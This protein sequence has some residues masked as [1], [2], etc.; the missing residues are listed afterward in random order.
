[1]VLWRFGDV[2]K[3]NKIEKDRRNHFR[4]NVFIKLLGSFILV[5]FI[6][7]II[8]IFLYNNVESSLIENANQSNQALLEQAQIV[9][10]SKIK[11][12]D[13]LTLQIAL[14]PNLQLLLFSGES[15][16]P[17]DNYKYIEFIKQLSRYRTVSNFIEEFYVYFADTDVILTTAIKTNSFMFYNFIQDYK[18][19]EI[20]EVMDILQSYQLKTYLPSQQMRTITDGNKITFVQSLPLGEKSDIKGSFVILIDENKIKELLLNQEGMQGSYYILNRN[21]EMIFSTDMNEENYA[22]IQKGLGV[23]SNRFYTLDDHE[24][25]I[26]YRLSALNDWT[27]VSIV[28]KDIVLSRVNEVK[29]LALVLVLLCLLAG[30]IVS[31]YLTYKNHSPIRDVIHAILTGKQESNHETTIKNEFDFIKNAV[32][33][34]L[35]EENKLR[36]V[37]NQ[38]APVIKADFISRLIKGNVDASSITKKD[39]DFMGVHFPTIYFRVVIIHI[40]DCNRFIQEDTERERALIRFIILNLSHELLK[41]T[42]YV[43]EIE[44]D[45]IA[46]LLNQTE[47]ASKNVLQLKEFIE[48]LREI[49]ENR[50]KTL[51]TVAV[52]KTVDGMKHIPKAYLGALMALDHKMIQGQHS[53]IFYDDIQII[54]NDYFFYSMEAE[55]QIMNYAKSGDYHNIEKMLNHIFE[56]NFHKSGISPE[57]GKCLFFEIFSTILKLLNSMDKD[58]I[59]Y[60]F[61]GEDNPVKYFIRIE[62]AEEMQTKLKEIYFKICTMI[63]NE[64]SD[65][66]EQLLQRIETF[67]QENYHDS[68]LS[69]TVIAD[70]CGLNSS[71]LSSFYKKYSKQNVTEYLASVRITNA[72]KLL[73]EESFTI[74][75]ISEKVGY[76]NDVGLIRVFKKIEGITPGKYRANTQKKLS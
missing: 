42:G 30:I 70:H 25:I 35:N 41:E 58:H 75:Q 72:K 27:Y 39:L 6:P 36:N 40:D 67:I 49:V 4:Q 45:R 16:Q 46:I 33:T 54:K 19:M 68:S 34:S 51:I 73:K 62:T 64:R 74:S 11:E 3:K 60:L 37:L 24:K 57:M 32:V 65:H 66:S 15:S 17:L 44:R 1:M 52:S 20:N 61:E 13:Q 55:A 50:F 7:V 8:G 53:V 43:I 31:Y 71:Y 38:Q 63:E 76:M 47:L 22:Q 9:V 28:P 59:P 2:F 12:V 29:S 56:V 14:N 5:F 23:E 26:S 10:D 21:Q 48:N 18:E 69:L